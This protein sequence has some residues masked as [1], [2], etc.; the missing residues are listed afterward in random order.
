MPSKQDIIKETQVT[1]EEWKTAEDVQETEQTEYSVLHPTVI[2]T[3]EVSTLPASLSSSV[4]MQGN[5]LRKHD[6]EGPLKK[7][8][9][10]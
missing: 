5:L 1:V 7:A 6:L 8:Q 2:V 4:S 3:E 9:N 10:R